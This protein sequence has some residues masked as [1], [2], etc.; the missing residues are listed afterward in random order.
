MN[1]AT[2]NWRLM[3]TILTVCHLYDKEKNYIGFDEVA[4]E[5]SFPITFLKKAMP[6]YS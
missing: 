5:E 4:P 2:W 1:E 3:K 6:D